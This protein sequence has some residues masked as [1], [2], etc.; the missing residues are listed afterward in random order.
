MDLLLSFLIW[1][2]LLVFAYFFCTNLGEYSAK[3]GQLFPEGRFFRTLE[4]AGLYVSM[5]GLV[6]LAG[7][8]LWMM[9]LAYDTGVVAEILGF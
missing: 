5:M 3:D 7:G 8:I 6:W 2:V 4:K 1:I 9:Y